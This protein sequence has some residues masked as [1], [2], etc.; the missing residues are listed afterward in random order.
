MVAQVE[1]HLGGID[2]LINDTGIAHPRKLEE[3]TE[4]DGTKCS[5]L[6]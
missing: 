3:I 4:T 6:I 2:I 1:A 5:S